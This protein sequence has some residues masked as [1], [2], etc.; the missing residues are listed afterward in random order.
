M[1]AP[2]Q[3]ESSTNKV[4][5]NTLNQKPSATDIAINRC[6]KIIT[7]N[8]RSNLSIVV[9]I[10]LILGT[11]LTYFWI[12]NHI[13]EAT[14]KETLKQ[15]YTTVK[16]QNALLDTMVREDSMLKNRLYFYV[17]AKNL[18]NQTSSNGNAEIDNNNN[19]LIDYGIILVG[20][21]S[22]SVLTGFYRY[23][24]KEIS[25]AEQNLIAFHRIRIA[26]YNF[27]KGGYDELIRTTLV[28]N[29]FYYVTNEEG[30]LLPKKKIIESPLPGYP[31]ADITTSLI[32]KL[33]ES[34]EIVPKATK[35][36]EH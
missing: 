21:I 8:R 1:T 23:H 32:N 25:K 12:S 27:D 35:P 9:G 13:T 30:S 4:Q 22:I 19:K 5:E 3:N 34:V 36:G 29:A 15:L 33:L 20:I 11:V 2:Q 7:E 24:L 18:S 28:K 26:A 14:S 16:E 6:E 31:A 17:R 10:I